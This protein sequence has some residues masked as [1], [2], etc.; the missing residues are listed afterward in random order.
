MSR[1]VRKFT[2]TAK[3]VSEVEE[4]DL[5]G[6]F[7]SHNNLVRAFT[8]LGK[9]IS[10]DRH[11]GGFVATVVFPATTTVAIQHFLGVIPKYRVIL[12]QEG[13]GVLSDIPSGWNNKVISIRNNGAVEV[14]ATILIARE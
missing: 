10:F 3:E 13:N 4:G 9:F 5:K 8:L 6:L 1:F 11:F 2:P 7:E 12:R 14:K